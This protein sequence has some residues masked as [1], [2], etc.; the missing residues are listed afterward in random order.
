[1]FLRLVDGC[2][3]PR[4][5]TAKKICAH[6][7]RLLDMP[8]IGCDKCGLV[9]CATC[10][11][12]GGQLLEHGGPIARCFMCQLVPDNDQMEEEEEDDD[13]RDDE[14]D[15]DDDDDIEDEV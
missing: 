1:M 10:W 4:I 14:D 8:N 12:T 6:C 13:E 9:C 15:D 11:Q 5:A 2:V 3:V 7:P